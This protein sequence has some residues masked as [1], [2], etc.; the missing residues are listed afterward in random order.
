M[1]SATK[2]VN[3]HAANTI[4]ERLKRAK[5]INPSS[6]DITENKPIVMAETKDKSAQSVMWQQYK[7]ARPSVRTITS[8]GKRICFTNYEYFTREKDVVEWLD[9][10][11]SNY[12]LPGITKGELMS[13]SER[14]PM[15]KLKKQ[16]IA[17]YL[18]AE[19]V[20]KIATARG[21]Y[22]DMG[23]TE[24]GANINPATSRI[25]AN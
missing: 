13:T 15:E 5:I 1:T 8:S 6:N 21:E 17:E 18:A 3:T 19:E 22:K 23:S 10:E 2:N 7:S 4:A 9:S 16:H 25:V 14:D 20:A 24:K 11:I 12:G